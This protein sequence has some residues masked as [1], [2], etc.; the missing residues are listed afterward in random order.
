MVQKRQYLGIALGGPGVVAGEQ[1]MRVAIDRNRIR[2]DSGSSV[3]V[4]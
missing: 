2:P 4:N 1:V 3:T